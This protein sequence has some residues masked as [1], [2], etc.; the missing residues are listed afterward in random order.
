MGFWNFKVSDTVEVDSNG[1]A[2][3]DLRR[4]FKKAH[5]RTQLRHL[6]NKRDAA[7]IL[8]NKLR[9]PAPIK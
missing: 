7:R 9:V 6:R 8:A 1:H 4:L 2:T 5:V 3:V